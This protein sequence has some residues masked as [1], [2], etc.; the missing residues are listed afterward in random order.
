MQQRNIGNEIIVALSVVVVLAFAITFAVVLSL[1]NTDQATPTSG[2]NVAADGT[3]SGEN[4]NVDSVPSATSTLFETLVSM[5]QNCILYTVEANDT[6]ESIAD[7]FGVSADDIAFVNSLTQ[8]SIL[9][10]EQNLIV[11]LVGCV[12]LPTGE[13][14]T[15][16]EVPTSAETAV[17]TTTISTV[18]DMPTVEPS[19]TDNLAVLTATATRNTLS[20]LP[21]DV[22]TD[23]TPLRSTN[24]ATATLTLTPTA[25]LTETATET[26]TDIPTE[27]PTLIAPSE[28]PTPTATET[29]TFTLVPPTETPTD[30]PTDVST[31]TYT[32]TIPTPTDTLTSTVTLVPTSTDIPTTTFTF[33]PTPTDTA[34]LTAT[35]TPTATPTDTSTA[36]QTATATDSPTPTFTPVLDIG[37]QPTPTFPQV[38]ILLTP[39]PSLT[40]VPTLPPAQ[41]FCLAVPQDWV[42]YTV[43]E[44]NT[45]LAIAQAANTTV[46]DLLRVNCLSDADS[47]TAGMEIYVPRAPVNLVATGLPPATFVPSALCYDTESVQISAPTIGQQVSGI[48]TI[49]GTA[50]LPDFRY[51]RIDIRYPDSDTY[52]FLTAFNVPIVDG[53]LGQLDT[54]TLDNGLYWLRL[55]VVNRSGNVPFNAICSV[56]VYIAN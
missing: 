28:T 22:G 52:E 14:T 37:F 44:G 6:L 51:Y 35:F 19:S 39:T 31:E 34:T 16:V 46:L 7:V 48:I 1:T 2:A 8:E 23:I 17:A 26:P 53:V 55:S 9:Q 43:Q 38:D 50:T 20:S 15:V 27:T 49:I 11:P 24:T 41:D 33:T 13:P 5:P 36:T 4:T 29:P 12:L 54:Q 10:P 21:T 56:P 30:T 40:S 45:L 42:I 32:P 25:T 47:I 3:E 18:T